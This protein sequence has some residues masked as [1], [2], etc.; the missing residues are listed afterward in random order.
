M[1]WT[2]PARCSRT[3]GGPGASC[4]K[5]GRS[6]RPPRPSASTPL[7]LARAR[8]ET[9]AARQ[10]VDGAIAEVDAGPGSCGRAPRNAGCRP[11]TSRW[12]RSRGRPRSSSTPRPAARRAGQAGPGGGGSRRAD[13][14]DRTA[15]ARLRRGR[16][17]T[18]R[19]GAAA[20]GPGRGVPDAGR[21]PAG[22]RRAGPGADPGDRERSSRR[23][24]GPTASSTRGSAPSTTRPPARETELRSQRLSLAE[25]VG[26][27]YEQAGLFGEYARPDLR[28]LAGV[29]AAES[30]PDPARWPDAA[31]AAEELADA[32]ASAGGSPPDPAA[33]ARA[34]L[35]PGVTAILDA[36]AAATRG[37]RA[38]DRGHAE[39]H[40]GPDVGGAEGVHRGTDR[41]RRGLP[42]RLGPRR[43]RDR[44]RDRRRGAQAG[45]PVRYPDR[46]ARRRPGRAPGRPGTQGT[47]G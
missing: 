12:T 21:D 14:D 44:A 45:R 5:P 42:G 34:V 22:R 29:T 37:G 46:R 16:R 33:A 2:G 3:S 25:A 7:L 17:G 38:G 27:L 47:G 10:A 15:Q 1:S 19:A 20:A 13:R 32:L 11:R 41:L 40:R 30:W 23:P 31:R 18:R 36:F 43:R 4:R 35:P 28:P 9:A 26:Q 8:D 24:N 39:E 6:R